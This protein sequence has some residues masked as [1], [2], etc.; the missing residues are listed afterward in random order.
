MKIV[1][2]EMFIDYVDDIEYAIRHSGFKFDGIYGV[3]RGGMIPAVMLS[4][5]LSIPYLN[6]LDRVISNSCIL[7]VDEICDTGKTLK[8][9]NDYN[10]FYAND[11]NVEYKYAVLLKREG[12]SFKPDFY[13]DEVGKGILVKFPWESS[14]SCKEVPA[15]WK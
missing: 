10:K 9:V 8:K 14:S 3:P 12:A 2:W 6:Q 4:H 5:A 7:I 11:N 13:Y 15:S 1:T